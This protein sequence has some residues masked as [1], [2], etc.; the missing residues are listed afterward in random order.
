MDFP[1][2]LRESIEADWTLLCQE[3]D[4]LYPPP[5]RFPSKRRQAM[6]KTTDQVYFLGGPPRK[7]FRFTIPVTNVTKRSEIHDA[8][9]DATQHV[10][11]WI[12]TKPE[13]TDDLLREV[14]SAGHGRGRPQ[15][16]RLL[17][18]FP[19]RLDSLAALEELFSPVAWGTN[20]FRLLPYEELAEALNA[21]HRH[22][23]FIGGFVDPKTETLIL[24]RGD[25][26]R[27]AVPLSLLKSLGDGPKPDPT[28][29]AFTDFGQTVRLGDYEAAN[30][31]ILYEVDPEYRRGVN[32]KRQ[33]N[34][35]SFGASLRRLRVLKGLRQS[36]FPSLPAKTIARIERGEVGRPHQA[37]LQKIAKRLGVESD[38]IE[39]F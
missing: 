28:A 34:E 8:I 21:P 32:A 24:Y 37:T 18:L 16:G 30:D 1:D 26:D 38:E 20:G 35:M 13:S 33:D 19:P 36:D 10:S 39:T 25:F 31:A 3:W 22:D 9:V 14:W 4:A 5:I 6:T 27:I 2:T 7:R 29:L 15:L 17:M 11:L 12:A 23:L